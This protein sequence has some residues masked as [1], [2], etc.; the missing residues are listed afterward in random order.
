MRKE[1]LI[2]PI[3]G[4]KNLSSYEETGLSNA[5]TTDTIT[6]REQ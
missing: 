2:R 6:R 5:S 3:A 4:S 1:W